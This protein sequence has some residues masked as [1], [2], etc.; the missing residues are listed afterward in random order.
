MASFGQILK[1]SD[2]ELK[3][4]LIQKFLEKIKFK[5]NQEALTVYSQPA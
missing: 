3:K 1:I 2:K 4:I 5:E